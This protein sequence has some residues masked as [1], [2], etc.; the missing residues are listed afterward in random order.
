MGLFEPQHLVIILIIALVIFGPGKIAELG[1][2]LGRGV[3]DFKKA[4]AEPET[5]GA[6][7]AAVGRRRGITDPSFRAAAPEYDGDPAGDAQQGKR[8]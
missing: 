1:G 5:T 3:R 2:S 6:A 4:M 8:L 7:A